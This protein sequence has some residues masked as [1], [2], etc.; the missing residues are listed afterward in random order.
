MGEPLRQSSAT[1][2]QA[3]CLLVKHQY[4]SHKRTVRSANDLGER[5]LRAR[6]EFG[7]MQKPPRPI[8]QSEVGEALGVT[9]VAVGAWEG[10][11]RVPDLGTIQKLASVLGVRAS[12]LAFN[13]GPMRDVTPE[14]QERRTVVHHPTRP[15]HPDMKPKDEPNSA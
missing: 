13:D 7:A 1:T 14:E 5:L 15:E 2:L 8:S 12:W 10:G 4:Y 11:K 6:L 9:G 3:D